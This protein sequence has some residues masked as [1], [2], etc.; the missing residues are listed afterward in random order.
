MGPVQRAHIT[1]G[2]LVVIQ[3]IA[4][5]RCRGQPV[6]PVIPFVAKFGLQGDGRGDNPVFLFGKGGVIGKQPNFKLCMAG[7]LEI[8]RLKRY[9][10]Q[11]E[12]AI[13]IPNRRPAGLT[14]TLTHG[15]KAAGTE[16]GFV[17][18]NRKLI[19]RKT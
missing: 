6:A 9:R 11:K 17:E 1:V 15:P 5:E 2:A 14:D 19:L 3:I 18:A 8:S 10:L 12:A 4:E 13:T 7:K 16:I